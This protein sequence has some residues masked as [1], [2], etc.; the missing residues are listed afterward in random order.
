MDNQLGIW[1]DKEKAILITLLGDNHSVKCI[2]S[3]IVSKKRIEGEGKD[4]GKFGDQYTNAEKHTE[5]KIK[6]QTVIY[7]EEIIIEIKKANDVVVFGPAEM[8]KEL[9]KFVRSK[10]DMANIKLEVKT[11]D[12]MTDNQRVAWVKEYFAN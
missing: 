2:E 8:K 7:L 12:N 4:F 11:A 3:G 5:N 9:A 1:I 10:N 6:Q